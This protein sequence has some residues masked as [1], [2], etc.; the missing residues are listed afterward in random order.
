MGNV[1]DR[2]IPGSF[3]YDFDVRVPLLNNYTYTILRIDYDID[4]YPVRVRAE[5]PPTDTSCDDEE[6]F[7]N[8]I[9]AILSS[10]EI[11]SVVAKLVSQAT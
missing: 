3:G 9:A 1:D 6:E 10:E 11:K 2:E 8:A 7:V 5:R 4:L